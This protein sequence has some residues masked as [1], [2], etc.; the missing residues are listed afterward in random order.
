[1]P[2][3]KRSNDWLAVSLAVI[4]LPVCAAAEV[5]G[6]D[7]TPE[8]LPRIESPH[9]DIVYLQDAASLQRFSKVYLVECTVTFRENWKKD[10]NQTVADV[11]RRVSDKD[12]A[13]IQSRLSGELGEVFTREFENAGFEIATGL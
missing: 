11:R 8:R 1:M 3:A 12:M 7:V 6:P 5:D 2:G 13:R 4:A 10:Y 9:G